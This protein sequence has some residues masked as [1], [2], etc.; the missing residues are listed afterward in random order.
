[1]KETDISKVIIKEY[2]K[3]LINSL[4]ND[5]AIVGAGPA[6]LTA[7][8]YLAKSGAKT[9]VLEKRLS[10]GG[11][12]WGGATGYNVVSFENKDILEEICVKTKRKGRLYIADSI[13]FA[14]ALGYKA[15]QAGAEIFNLTEV[16]DVI[17]K[18]DSI[19][20]LVVNNSAVNKLRLLVDPFCIASRYIIDAT[21]HSAEIVN[22]LKKKIKK[23]HLE[24]IKEGPMDVIKS[25]KQVVEKAGEVYPNV[26]VVGMSV[27]STY[28]IPRMG[29]IFGGMLESGKKVAELI[30]QKL[31]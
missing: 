28:N 29:P 23:F 1:M 26:Y 3:R 31:K 10:I 2:N 17:L 25:E 30:K 27:C 22:M 8:Y 5:V 20:G 24:E 14:T 6:G 9:L 19:K 12:I 13:E 7:A 11:G 4:E 15:K 21:G 18:N 16:E